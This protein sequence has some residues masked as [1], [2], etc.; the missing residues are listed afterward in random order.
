MEEVQD[1]SS[2]PGPALT[3]RRKQGAKDARKKLKAGSFGA[4]LQL[5]TRCSPQKSSSATTTRRV[6]RLW[7]SARS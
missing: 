3:G 1:F 4:C 5:H 7:A 6:Q 2:E